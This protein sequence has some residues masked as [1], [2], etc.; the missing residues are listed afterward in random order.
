MVEKAIIATLLLSSV[1]TWSLAEETDTLVSREIGEVYVTASPKETTSLGKRPIS[2]SVMGEAEMASK[3]IRSV[4]DI[5]AMIPNLF[6]PD[7]GSRQTSA[8][9]VRGIGSR[10][11]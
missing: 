2:L 4:K 5:G 1:S 3:G 11:G 8:M 9:Y 7:Y 10:I 6:I